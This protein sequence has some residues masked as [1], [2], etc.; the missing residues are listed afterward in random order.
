MGALRAEL[1]GCRKRGSTVGAH[2]AQGGRAL[3]A[4]LRAGPILVLASRARHREPRRYSRLS[5]R[6]EH[7][8][9][10]GERRRSVRITPP[11]TGRSEQREPRS[12][13]AACSAW[14]KSPS[15]ESRRQPDH[16]APGG[17]EG[18]PSDEAFR[19]MALIL[20]L[21]A[22]ARTRETT[23]GANSDESGGTRWL[24]SARHPPT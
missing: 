4:E 5:G 14:R 12:G 10:S 1:R 17:I 13:A 8:R 23:R 2:A 22:D 7:S 20:R 6:R 9:A 16:S 15:R 19:P 21:I 18:R 24:T 3:L 11:L